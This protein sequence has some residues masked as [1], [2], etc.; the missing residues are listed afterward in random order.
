MECD[1]LV[2]K[3]GRPVVNVCLKQIMEIIQ[4]CRDLVKTKKGPPL[5]FNIHQLP[6]WNQVWNGIFP[7]ESVYG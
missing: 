4:Q 2:K 5:P 6:F 1:T 3:I 7:G